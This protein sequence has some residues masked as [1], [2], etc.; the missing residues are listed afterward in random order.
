MIRRT[1]NLDVGSGNLQ[2]QGVPLRPLIHIHILAIAVLKAQLI[3]HASA[4]TSAWWETTMAQAA[5]TLLQATIVQG[6]TKA[7]D[8][9]HEQKFYGMS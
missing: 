3:I 4:W 6:R 2:Q 7:G 1:H 5:L 8:E 9:E